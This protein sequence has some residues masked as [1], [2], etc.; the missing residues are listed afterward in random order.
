MHRAG[1]AGLRLSYTENKPVLILFGTLRRKPERPRLKSPYKQAASA[2]RILRD[3]LSSISGNG[4]ISTI[5][6]Q[7]L[8]AFTDQSR[9][10]K[11]DVTPAALLLQICS[12][13][14]CSTSVF[15]YSH[16]DVPPPLWW[17]QCPA[18]VEGLNN[19][20]SCHHRTEG[21][22]HISYVIR[23]PM[24]LLRLQRHMRVRS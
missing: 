7:R 23:G 14:I 13:S 2:L 10:G 19:L 18:V 16:A 24:I 12:V 20:P 15:L 21:M 8:D 17:Q 11:T 4:G 3:E 1:A 9:P 22:G 5:T 6:Q